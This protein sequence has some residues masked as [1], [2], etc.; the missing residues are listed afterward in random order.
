[1]MKK[2]QFFWVLVLL[3]ICNAAMSKT[4]PVTKASKLL[5]KHYYESAAN[6][7]MEKM[8]LLNNDSRAYM[9][10]GLTYHKNAILHKEIYDSSLDVEVKYMESLIK[11]YKKYKKNR[12]KYAYLYYGEA[13]MEAGDYLKAAKYFQRFYTR[14]SVDKNH[15]RLAKV[16]LGLSKYMLGEK[17]SAIKL[18]RNTNAKNNDVKAELARSLYVSGNDKS[19][20]IKLLD[21]LLVSMSKKNE[22]MSP[23]VLNSALVL[24][25]NQDNFKRALELLSKTDTST[26]V[27]VENIGKQKS[28]RFYSISLAKNMSSVYRAASLYYLNKVKNSKKYQA[29]AEYWLAE[30]TVVFTDS[31]KDLKNIGKL[32]SEKLPRNLAIRGE[33]QSQMLSYLKGRSKT[34]AAR[35]EA[36]AKTHNNNP[37]IVAQVLSACGR[38]KSKCPMTLGLAKALASKLSGKKIRT[39]NIAL[40]KYYLSKNRNEQALEYLEAG[41]DKNMKNRIDTNDPVLLVNLANAYLRNKIF[42]EN[43]EIYFELSKEFPVVRNIQN[44]VQGIYSMEYKSAGDVKIF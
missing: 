32:Y 30:S 13:L 41:R 40:G 15:K 26:P 16:L 29:M 24:Y 7:L 1:M 5:Q 23:R 22:K 20:A 33:I 17:K 34:A 25:A 2:Y 35:L 11:K 28:L 8:E 21:S 12:T 37:A 44:A 9:A 31:K 6:S 38:L 36:I 14:K 42:S 19:K 18:W 3:L 10:M 4:D 43:L 27:Y 39:L